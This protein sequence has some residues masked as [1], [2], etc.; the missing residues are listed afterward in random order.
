MQT[1]SICR[2]HIE[3]NRVTYRC[4]DVDTC[5]PECNVKRLEHLHIIDPTLSSPVKWITSHVSPTGARGEVPNTKVLGMCREEAFY[6]EIY[7]PEVRRNEY[8]SEKKIKFRRSTPN[9]KLCALATFVPIT[10]LLYK[11]LFSLVI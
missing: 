6:P 2:R 10:V 3:P 8:L 7:H 4:G 9:L 11:I 5:S 1:C